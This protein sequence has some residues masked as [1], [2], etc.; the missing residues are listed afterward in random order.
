MPQILK[1]NDNLTV[2]SEDNLELFVRSRTK[3]YFQGKV[4][5]ISS[6]NQTGEFDILPLHANF[7]TL[8]TKYLIMDKSLPT[9]K[10]IEFD[11]A[12][13]SVIEGKIDVYVGV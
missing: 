2:V 12:V 3:N 4:K 10:K 9:E 5:S 7:I 1:N 13:V 11:S 8:A 6:V